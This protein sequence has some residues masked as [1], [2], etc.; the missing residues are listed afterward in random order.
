MAA[1]KTSIYNLCNLAKSLSIYQLCKFTVQI[2]VLIAFQQTIYQGHICTYWSKMFLP[3][4]QNV[5]HFPELHIA[6][7][8]RCL[9]KRQALTHHIP[10]EL[11]FLYT[12]NL[13]FYTCKGTFELQVVIFDVRINL[14]MFH[15]TL[16]SDSM[17]IADL[18]TCCMCLTCKHMLCIV[19]QLQYKYKKFSMQQEVQNSK[20]QQSSFLHLL[21][22]TCRV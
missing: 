19:W 13:T 22:L 9:C 5:S 21:C 4:A 3:Q 8:C 12:S 16:T 14:G 15:Q 17:L 18:I 11:L 20:A 7:L 2:A 1:S 6:V 10:N